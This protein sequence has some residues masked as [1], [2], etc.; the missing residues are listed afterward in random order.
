MVCQFCKLKEASVHVTEIADN[1]VKK[2]DACAACAKE[3]NYNDPAA[4]AIA[5][6]LLGL[7]AAQ[8]ME[9]A[10]EAVGARSCDQCGYTQADFKKSGR[11]GCAHC[12]DIFSDGLDSV[13]KTMHKDIRH[14]GKVP[15][16][17]QSAMQSALEGA[18]RLQSLNRALQAAI[19]QED[20]ESAAQWRDAIKAFK[21]SE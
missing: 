4:F 8:K 15:A 14:R 10:S 7:G 13:L 19:A 5:D 3:K 12:Y 17:M 11:L 9:E 2:V 1:K 16:G 6:H 20:F 18:H 21:A